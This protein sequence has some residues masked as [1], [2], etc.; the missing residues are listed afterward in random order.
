MSDSSPI[1]SILS[2][3]SSPEVDALSAASGSDAALSRSHWLAAATLLVGVVGALGVASRPL[4]LRR[5]AP[6]AAHRDAVSAALLERRSVAGRVDPKVR[7]MAD[8]LA[9]LQAAQLQRH[10]NW[11]GFAAAPPPQPKKAHPPEPLA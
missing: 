4:L 8:R 10:P 1:A 11:H 3:F 7:A 9:A 6:A 5:F 2:R